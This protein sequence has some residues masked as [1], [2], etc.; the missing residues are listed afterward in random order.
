[1]LTTVRHAGHGV[2]VGAGAAFTHAAWGF[3]GG[4]GLGVVPAAWAW[5]VAWHAVQVPV[6]V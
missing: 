3:A 1:M 4:R 5:V 2:L 6:L